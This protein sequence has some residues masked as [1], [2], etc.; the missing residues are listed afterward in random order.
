MCKYNESNKPT[1]TG[2][3][4]KEVINLRYAGYIIDEE[5]KD[6]L[7]CKDFDWDFDKKLVKE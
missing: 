4:L 1:K 6:A 5:D 7:D 3:C 2:L